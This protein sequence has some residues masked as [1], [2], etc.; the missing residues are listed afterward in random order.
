MIEITRVEPKKIQRKLLTKEQK[1]LICEKHS[2]TDNEDGKRYC[3]IDCPLRV[4]ISDGMGG[5]MDWSCKQIS[6][7]EKSIEKYW[8]KKIEI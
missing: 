1:Q 8:N 7:I 3:D 2:C 5:N 4:E 6:I